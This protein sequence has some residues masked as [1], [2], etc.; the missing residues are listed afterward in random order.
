MRNSGIFGFSP[1]IVRNWTIMRNWCLLISVLWA[2]PYP[3]LLTVWK[4]SVPL[5]R[6]GHPRGPYFWRCLQKKVFFS[7]VRVRHFAPPLTPDLI[8]WYVVGRSRPIPM[9]HKTSKSMK[10]QGPF[11][12]F[13]ALKPWTFLS[14]VFD[15]KRYL[16]FDL[17][18]QTENFFT[19]DPGQTRCRTQPNMPC[20]NLRVSFAGNRFIWFKK[21]VS[22]VVGRFLKLLRFVPKSVY[23]IIRGRWVRIQVLFV[24][25]AGFFK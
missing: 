15:K 24:P 22:F 14:R 23:D 3:S 7:C 13:E 20:P 21:P 8:F 25:K 1:Q 4:Y 6:Y 11:R 19:S 10:P 12:S 5:L 16:T 18:L 17:Q 2:V 9:S